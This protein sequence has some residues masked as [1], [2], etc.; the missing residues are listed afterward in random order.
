MSISPEGGERDLAHIAA[1][2]AWVRRLAL[3]IAGDVHSGEDISQEALL[4]AAAPGHHRPGDLRAWFTGVVKNLARMRRRSDERRAAREQDVARTEL[5]DSPALALERLEIQEVLSQAVRELQEPY[6][7]TILLRWY[8]GLEPQEIARRTGTNQATVQTRLHRALGLLRQDLDRRSHGD[9]SRWLSVW[10]P[11]MAPLPSKPWMIAMTL[12]T[13]L[14]LAAVAVVACTSAVVYS[15]SGENELSWDLMS[16]GTIYRN[17]THNYPRPW[18]LGARKPAER[19]VEL[20]LPDHSYV[21]EG[22]AIR[23]SRNG[24]KIEEGSYRDGKRDGRWTY[25]KDDG[26]IDE[27][28]SGVYRNDARIEP[29]Q[30]GDN[31][32]QRLRRIGYTGEK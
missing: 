31:P 7:S 6:R 13:K 5:E 19:F 28:R 20:E 12:K 16:D 23:W 32:P 3:A 11:L 8:E 9:R 22:P 2:A 14:V 26:S 18:G 24:T 1:E 15:I 29:S 17:T 10:I 27:A 30:W 25:W 21:K 4:A